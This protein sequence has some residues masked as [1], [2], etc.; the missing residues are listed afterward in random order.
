MPTP[1][2]LSGTRARGRRGGRGG[3]GA[4]SRHGPGRHPETFPYM[5][6]SGAPRPATRSTMCHRPRVGSPPGGWGVVLRQVAGRA[7]AAHAARRPRRPPPWTP[8]AAGWP[9]PLIC[10]PLGYL[11]EVPP[12][13]PG[14]GG[15]PCD[16]IGPLKAGWFNTSRWVGGERSSSG[17]TKATYFPCVP[18]YVAENS[19]GQAGHAVILKPVCTQQQSL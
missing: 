15:L 4:G 14:P 18:F 16:P 3:Q 7:G 10:I 11:R 9:A 19:P 13:P 12:S 6:R 8:D 17:F 2:S 5:A 1:R